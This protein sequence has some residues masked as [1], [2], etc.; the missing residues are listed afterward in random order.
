MKMNIAMLIF[1]L[2]TLVN[3][4]DASLSRVINLESKLK[5]DDPVNHESKAAGTDIGSVDKLGDEASVGEGG[6]GV[7]HDGSKFVMAHHHRR[8]R[9][10]HRAPARVNAGS[11]HTASF[12]QVVVTILG[13]AAVLCFA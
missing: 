12:Q 9:H 8:H 2:L 1:V 6:R 11:Q 13:A 7:S 3:N 10:R 4:L 5:L